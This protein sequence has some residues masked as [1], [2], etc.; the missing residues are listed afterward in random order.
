MTTTKEDLITRIPHVV[1]GRLVEGD[2][3]EHRSRDRGATLITPSLD[4]AGLASPRSVAAP[5]SDVPLAEIL[6][7]LDELSG[8]LALSENAHLQWA[9]D[10]VAPL[11]T[12]PRSILEP[13][14]EGVAGAFRREVLETHLTGGLARAALDGWVSAG[15]V[16]GR[17]SAIRAV[18]PRLVHLLAGNSPIVAAVM[19]AWTSLLK[20]IGL[21]KMPSNDPCTAVAILRTMAEIDPEHPL[22]RSFSAVYWR[23]GDVAVESALMRPQYFDKIVAWGGDAALRHAKQYIGP[24]LELV[25]LDPKTSISMVGREAFDDGDSLRAA[26]VAAATDT[27]L[28]N[29]DACASSRIHFVEGDV[30]DV[31]R[32]CEALLPELGIA[33]TLATESN[34]PTPGELKDEIEVLRDLDPDYR[35]WGD[36][37][38]RGLIVRSPEPVDFH[39]DGRTVNVVPVDSLEEAALYATV[40]TQTVGVFPPDR[41]AGL[42]DHLGRQGVQR[43]VTLGEAGELELLA[44]LPHDGMY[45]LARMARWVVDQHGE[46]A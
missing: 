39:P 15:G 30:E 46:E 31:D 5:A 35:V 23:G 38:G 8:R 45:V 16:G 32:F 41:K 17:P 34:E 4:L 9:L 21:L 14:Y 2:D 44:G 27:T 19:I 36:Y 40:A 18:P 1:A 7:F 37:S 3:V 13:Q 22:V 26:A 24:G 11:S 43:I 25:A 6:D 42:R 12:A 28:L 20:G 29:Q 10:T 33:R